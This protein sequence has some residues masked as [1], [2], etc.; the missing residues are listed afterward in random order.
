MTVTPF[1]PPPSF[2]SGIAQARAAHARWAVEY[3]EAAA[4]AFRLN[5]PE[6]VCWAKNCNV[7]LTAAMHK[8]GMADLCA[9]S[10]EVSPVQSGP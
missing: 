1:Y 3:E 8:A 2:E 4:E 6:A 7:I 10:S 5:H 9:G